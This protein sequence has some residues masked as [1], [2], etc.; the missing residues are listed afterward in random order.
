MS[1]GKGAKRDAQRGERIR[2]WRKERGWNQGELADSLGVD[3][4]TV[5]D[6]EKGASFSADNLLKIAEQFGTSPEMVM[7]GHDTKSWPFPR[8]SFAL[9]Q[10]LDDTQRSFVEG[11]LAAAIEEEL[12]R[13]R[14]QVERLGQER[15]FTPSVE[16]DSRRKVGPALK[17]AI[18]TKG[19]TK[20]EA[21]KSD[22]VQKPRT[23]G[24]S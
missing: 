6:I 14:T 20:R 7:R 8:V 19:K 11:R 17:G 10:A 12:L 13:S 22:G 4:S 1:N 16:K 3:Q 2:S 5:S 23:R 9:F 18:V 15:H 24:R 21:S